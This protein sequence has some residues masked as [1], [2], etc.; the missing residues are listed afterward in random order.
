[1]SVDLFTFYGMEMVEDEGPRGDDLQL[2]G[3]CPFCGKEGHFFANPKTFLW[4]CKVCLEEGNPTTFIRLFHAMAV[5]ETSAADYKA[6]AKDRG[7]KVDTLKR[8]GVCFN[9]WTEEWMI[10]QTNL[11]GEVVNLYVY[12]ELEG[13]MLVM[14]PPGQ[15]T[16]LFGLDTLEDK[17]EAWICEGPWDGMAWEEVLGSLTKRGSKLV[18]VSDISAS[19]MTT[20]AVLAVPGCGTFKKVWASLFTDKAVHVCYDNDYPK[21]HRGKK[22][23]STY[24]PGWKGAQRAA[25]YL[26]DEAQSV[27]L[28]TWG[29]KG[30]SKSRADGF[31]LRDFYHEEGAAKVFTKVAKML[32]AP[33]ETQG[34]KEAK[35]KAKTKVKKIVEAKTCESFKSLLDVYKHYLKITPHFETTLAMM[36]AV[37]KST[38]MAGD[39]VWLRVIGPPGT[40]KTTIAEAMSPAKEYIYSISKFR[41]LVS[42]YKPRGKEKGQKPG[43]VHLIENKLSIIK[44]ADTLLSNPKKNEI[45]G[46][47]RDAWDRVIR[48]QYLNLEGEEFEDINNTWCL[49]GTDS[50]RT[51]DRSCLGERFL[52]CEIFAGDEQSQI[53]LDKAVQMTISKIA[54]G[55]S[56]SNEK[57]KTDLASHT[58]GFLCWLHEGTH[59][60]PDFPVDYQKRITHMAELAA[61][62]RTKPGEIQQ[63]G[64][65]PRVELATRLSTQLTKTAI[66]LAMLLGRKTID[67][68]VMKHLKK[69]AID[70]SKGFAFE[71][72]ELIYKSKR[73]LTST[74]LSEM[75]HLSPATITRYLGT[76]KDVGFIQRNITPNKSGA[77]GRHRHEILLTPKGQ[78]IIK[79]SG[80]VSKK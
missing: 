42:G 27:D 41:G 34:E 16:G 29:A 20:H 44:D 65:R 9:T 70:T 49:C 57:M 75:L 61:Y 59:T 56:A 23:T 19:L 50:L 14:C 64:L 46:E 11:G 7:L 74:D 35:S 30:F 2:K 40:G 47:L 38:N 28:L 6:L 63:L 26:E 79:S 76:M 18:K 31:D 4:D 72:A 62:M 80:V 45:L 21:R 37:S 36:L 17:D 24:S 48:S 22:G 78:S 55:K 39:Q 8:W 71:I 73:G 77:R 51:L 3:D 52:D 32:K 25:N 13:K 43:I 67:G 33:P 69:V 53:Y 1:M 60:V 58:Y 15:H 54:S 68:V 66:C 12:R 10:P 5:A